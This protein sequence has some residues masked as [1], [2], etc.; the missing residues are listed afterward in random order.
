MKIEIINRRYERDVGKD[1]LND[2]I[3]NEKWSV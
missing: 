1:E 2:I 3:I